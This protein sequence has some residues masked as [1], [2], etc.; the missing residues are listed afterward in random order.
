MRPI[1]FQ[2]KMKVIELYLEGLST[3]G[4]VAKTG[5]SKGAVISILKDAR[6]GKFPGLVLRDKIDEL[7]ALSVRLKKEALDLTQARLGFTFLRRVLD[8]DIEPD[9]LKEWVDF[10][11]EISPT[12][13]EGFIPTVMELFHIEK[14]TGKGYGEIAS[15]VKEL[16]SQ[17][18]KLVREV[19]DLKANEIRAKELRA[20]IEKT[21]EQ[22]NKLTVEKSK[23]ESTV[24]SLD[25]FLQKRVG[26]LA[27][28]CILDEDILTIDPPA[29]RDVKNLMTIVGGKIVYNAKPDYLSVK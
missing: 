3:N 25:G 17:R 4:I 29:I 21:Q 19:E 13:P 15:E 16:S 28:F 26:K 9:K 24:G 22:V 1:A 7:H 18:E 5:I 23:L 27:D 14:A 20:E 11:S 10:C 8:M 12:P 2:Q 6:E